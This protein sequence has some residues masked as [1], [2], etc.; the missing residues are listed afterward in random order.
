MP[1]PGVLDPAD[2][3]YERYFPPLPVGVPRVAEVWTWQQHRVHV[4]H[5]GE[6][7]APVRVVLVHGA[8][9][10]AAAMWP[11]AAQLACLGARVT[12]PDLPGY[13]RT[14]TRQPHKVQYHHWGDLMADLVAK[15]ADARPLIIAGA[16]LGGMLALDAATRTG[17]ADAVVA[18]CLLDMSNSAVREATFRTSWLA[19]LGPAL[20]TIAA[21][22]LAS[23][24]L[25]LRWVSRMH[26]IT[27]DKDL[28]AELLADHR[29]AGTRSSLRWMRSLV[30]AQPHTPAEKVTVPVLLV[31]G[32]QDRW[33]PMPL[34]LDYL[35]RIPAPTAAVPLVGSGHFPT[36]DAGL[37][38][39]LNSVAHVIDALATAPAEERRTAVSQALR[40]LDDSDGTPPPAARFGAARVRFLKQT[41][42]TPA[43][44]F[45]HAEPRLGVGARIR[46]AI[47]WPA[48]RAPIAT[49]VVTSHR[50]G[51]SVSVP[52][53]MV[54]VGGHRYV[55][56]I[57]G[58]QSQ[59]PQHVR[60]ADGAVTLRHGRT[61]H[62]RL[63]ELGDDHAQRARVLQAYLRTNPE[64]RHLVPVDHTASLTQLSDV[65]AH[66]P[67]FRVRARKP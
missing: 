55:V 14:L 48:R 1:T 3:R 50:T 2:F 16:S 17:H 38:T 26:K 39:L 23:T 8:G 6:P 51:A 57:R 34:S 44:E 53:A 47:A 46:A 37:A 64:A 29:G 9:G 45:A 67:M 18:T 19:K 49:V 43:D 11:L 36:E 13:G 32:D 12:V 54:R 42:V 59:W 25:P 15:E 63:V 52:L 7:D 4:E 41:V 58:E 22:P 40:A 61:E 33:T 31:H 20:L 5:V 62:V 56:A 27:N 28:L 24:R 65:A 60:A 21:G 66:L 35:R 30:E 10:N